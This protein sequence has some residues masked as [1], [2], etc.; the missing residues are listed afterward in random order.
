M[1]ATV[2]NLKNTS[3]E[4]LSNEEV[5]RKFQIKNLDREG[6][7]SFEY[8]ECSINATLREIIK[9]AEEVVY[10]WNVTH[11]NLNKYRSP[12]LGHLKLTHHLKVVE[13]VP[14]LK[15]GG[16]VVKRGYT[17]RGGLKFDMVR[18]GRS[19]KSILGEVCE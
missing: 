18:R 2:K 15:E 19:H 3:I 4:T 5:M 9:K 14:P 11:E 7:G 8:F 17:K 1:S 16:K 10:L 6:G 13:Y 12:L